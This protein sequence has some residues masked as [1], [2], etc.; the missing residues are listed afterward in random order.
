VPASGTYPF[1]AIAAV[2]ITRTRLR[3]KNRARPIGDPLGLGLPCNGMATF[4][5]TLP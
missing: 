4:L 1:A 2:M 5:S 3:V